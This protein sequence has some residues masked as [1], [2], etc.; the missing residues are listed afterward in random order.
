MP[1]QHPFR[2]RTALVT[3]ASGGIGEE[4]ALGLARSGA[5]LVL[6]AR[7][8]DKLDALAERI[9]AEHGVRAESIVTDLA[10][11]DGVDRVIDGLADRRIDVLVANAGVGSH[12]P[13]VEESPER[14]RAQVALNVSAVTRLVGA[15][16]PPM[17]ARGVGGVMT[18]ASTAAFQPTP[19]MAVYGATKAFVLSFTE[20]VWQETRGRGVRVLALCPGPTETG[21]FAATGSENVM[22]RGRQTAAQ[23]AEVGLRAFARAGGPTVVSGLANTVTA[24]A[25]R[26]F[27]R[28]LMA[29]MS[30]MYTAASD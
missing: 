6:V 16:L 26:F 14:T 2:D 12:G 4:I 29:R 18:V 5:H 21:F 23:V 9:R 3:G 7:S 11:D 15:F 20:S 17:L 1:N 24:S 19:D 27:P 28:G 25:H 10:T 13:F 8:S 22:E 30:A